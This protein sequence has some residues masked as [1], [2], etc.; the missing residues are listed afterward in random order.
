MAKKPTAGDQYRKRAD[1]IGK[2]LKTR[3]TKEQGPM[4]KKKKALN[5]MADNEDW[6]DGKRKA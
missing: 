5:D 4:M 1:D 2:R 6:L 3:T